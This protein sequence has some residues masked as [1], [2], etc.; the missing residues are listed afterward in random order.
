MRQLAHRALNYLQD[1]GFPATEL[2]G[3]GG[4]PVPYHL[5][6][7]FELAELRLDGRPVTLATDH[8]AH[9][10]PADIE[11]LMS[12]LGTLVGATVVYVT[13][14]LTSYERKRLIERRVPFLVPGN[15]LYLPPLGIDLRETF[16]STHQRHQLSPSAQA[17]LIAILEHPAWSR[18]LTATDIAAKLEYSTMTASRAA[19]DLA[20]AGLARLEKVSRGH[21]IILTRSPKQTWDLALPLLRS[22]VQRTVFAKMFAYQ[23]PTGLGA[24]VSAG[25][26]ELAR[27][28]MLAEDGPAVF[29]CSR[30]SWNGWKKWVEVVP[31]RDSNTD[32]VQ[33]WSYPPT[34]KDDLENRRAMTRID[35][36]SLYL[37]LRDNNEPRV[38]AALEDLMEQAWQSKG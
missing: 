36:F 25:I 2:S 29:A 38:Q 30:E 37:S 7:S 4:A 8:D 15:Q 21:L 18:S 31:H 13:K 32:D 22:P 1:L 35:P 5:L 24:I 26:T 17:I 28:T 34:L 19:R 33:I 6:D 27:R 14:S 11:R 9:R 20:A 23:P 12:R 10:P 16:P 3:Y